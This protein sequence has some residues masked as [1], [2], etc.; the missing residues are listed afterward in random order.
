MIEMT[1][2]GLIGSGLGAGLTALVPS[3]L[4]AAASTAPTTDPLLDVAPE[5]R[6]AA[7][8]LLARLAKDQPLGLA[9][10][11]ERR[12]RPAYGPPPGP[13]V[14]W[15]ARSIPGPR[16][17]PEVTVYVVNARPGGSRPA[18]VHMHGGGFVTG[19]A[20]GEVAG[21]QELAAQLD[22]VIVTVEYRLAPETT[23]QGSIEDNYAALKWTSANAAELGVDP[24]RI[25]V[26]GGSAGGGHAAL[27]A[28]TARDRGEV[29]VLFQCL[30]FPMLDD[31]TG[32]TR[33]VPPQIGRIMWTPDNNR[34]GWRSFL[35]REPGRSGGPAGGVPARAASLAG[36]PPAFIGVGTIDLFV[37]E[38]VDY[39][40]R[41]IAAGVPTELHTVP[42]AFHS[43]QNIARG[44]QTAARFKGAIRDSLAR[45]FSDEA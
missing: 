17:A 4:A 13:D 1:R 5:L 29:P 31:R 10:L 40:R 38:N 19:S 6:P 37:E 43:F 18:I 28:L 35:G 30:I 32:T 26:M 11:A 24:A 9:T 7:R 27:L 45:A 16:G 33:R 2:R 25:A 12:A 21:L 15:S 39:A 23:Y 3:A 14:P 22:C 36:L 20:K 44:T 8:E 34:F 41:L 42:G